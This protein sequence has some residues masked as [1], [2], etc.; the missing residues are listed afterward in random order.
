MPVL[1]VHMVLH[2]KLPMRRNLKLETP[3]VFYATWI[4]LIGAHWKLRRQNTQGWITRSMGLMTHAREMRGGRIHLFPFLPSRVFSPR[5]LS[6]LASFITTR[7]FRQLS[8]C[9][10]SNYNHKACS[11]ASAFSERQAHSPGTENRR[12]FEFYITVHS[13]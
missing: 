3:A 8:I 10:S 12:C 9:S 7:V 2:I 13:T 5:V 11:C 1:Y 6:P 4:R